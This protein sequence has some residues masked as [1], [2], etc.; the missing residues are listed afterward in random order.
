MAAH[1]AIE[2]DRIGAIDL[3]DELVFRTGAN[4]AR[5][6]TTGQG[7]ARGIEGSL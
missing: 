6:E 1:R 7:S 5:E 2:P 3:D 4:E